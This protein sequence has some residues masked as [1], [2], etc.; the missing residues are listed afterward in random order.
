MTLFA[1]VA[2]LTSLRSFTSEI[3][4]P[5][6]MTVRSFVASGRNKKLLFPKC[7][8]ANGRSPKSRA[9]WHRGDLAGNHWCTENTLVIVLGGV[10][11]KLI[12]S[13]GSMRRAIDACVAYCI[14]CSDSAVSSAEPRQ[15]ER[16]SGW[17]PELL[18][19]LSSCCSGRAHYTFPEPTVRQNPRLAPLLITS[20]CDWTHR[21]TARIGILCCA[22]S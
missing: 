9:G 8:S 22:Q 3:R 6:M 16:H 10:V 4:S 19:L 5:E 21:Q 17:R 14:L 12:S 18:Q 15:A 13:L 7:L 1:S 11:V 20:A 2:D